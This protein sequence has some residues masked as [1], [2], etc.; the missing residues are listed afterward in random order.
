MV[1]N[2]R[3]LIMKACHKGGGTVIQGRMVEEAFAPGGK[4]G[5]GSSTGVIDSLRHG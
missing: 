3:D 5:C 4:K 1:L 2:L